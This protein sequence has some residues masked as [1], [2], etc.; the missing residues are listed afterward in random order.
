TSDTGNISVTG[1]PSEGIKS[2]GNAQGGGGSITLTALVGSVSINTQIV[3]KGGD[4]SSCF[5][6]L[7]VGQ[8]ITS[9]AQGVLDMRASGV[10]DGGD[11]SAVA[12]GNIT[13][14]GNIL[15]NGSS[16]DLDGGD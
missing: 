2:F 4:C 10:G 16:D 13:L 14:A 12:S 5:I 11:M 6:D 3:P 15:A 9:T 1:D 7:F 8:D